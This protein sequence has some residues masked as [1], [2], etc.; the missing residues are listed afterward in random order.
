MTRSTPFDQMP[1]PKQ[2]GILCNDQQFQAFIGQLLIKEGVT[3]NASACAEF[4]RQHCK[5][6]SRRDLT[7]HPR[8]REAFDQLRTDF[9]AWRGR[10][11]TQR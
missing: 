7:T 1:A 4:I 8:A 6:K 9:D 11:P 3:C 5:I 10:I 2:A